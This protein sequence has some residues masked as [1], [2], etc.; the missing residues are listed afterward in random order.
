MCFTGSPTEYLNIC[1]NMPVIEE[2][3]ELPPE[4]APLS[5]EVR[6]K[7]IQQCFCMCTVC[8]CIPTL[9]YTV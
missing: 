5:P 8:T 4:S 1:V 6:W 9:H 2:E 3:V 7:D